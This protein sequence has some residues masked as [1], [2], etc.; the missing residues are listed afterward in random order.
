MN[1]ENDKIL[2]ALENPRYTW[3]TILG[4]SKE[5]GLDPSVIAEFIS[6]NNDNIVK[7][8][9]KSKN[10]EDLFTTRNHF[11]KKAKPLDKLFGAFTN[12]LD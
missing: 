8:S 1:F 10:G 6:K 9:L 2:M 11:R 4:L 12:R 3:R 5:T 7:S